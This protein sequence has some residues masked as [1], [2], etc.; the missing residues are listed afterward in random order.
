MNDK[1]YYYEFKEPEAPL[2]S[3]GWNLVGRS[4]KDFIVRIDGLY[5][6]WKIEMKDGSPVPVRLS[7]N[8][9]TE[10]LAKQDIDDFLREEALKQEAH[11]VSLKTDV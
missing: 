3:Q 11:E 1:T 2:K 9:T 5:L 10:A 8:Y 4:Y 7:G 6:F